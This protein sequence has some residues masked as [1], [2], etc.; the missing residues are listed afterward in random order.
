MALLNSFKVDEATGQSLFFDAPPINRS[1]GGAVGGFQSDIQL[2]NQLYQPSNLGGRDQF[3]V[4]RGSVGNFQT[5][6]IIP[7]KPSFVGITK[8]EIIIFAVAVLIFYM[9]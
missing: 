2:T 7:K 8:N 9:L 5:E 6:I 4:D 1:S 3:A